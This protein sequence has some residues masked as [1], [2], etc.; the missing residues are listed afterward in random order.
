MSRKNKK[1]V[2]PD[3][4]P[5]DAASFLDSFELKRQEP[6]YDANG[7][8]DYYSEYYG[9]LKND[10]IDQYLDAYRKFKRTG[11]IESIKDPKKTESENADIESFIK[12]EI[13][14]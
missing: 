9:R 13:D 8:R 4:A 11:E 14:A 2:E 12:D 6:V 10:Y 3:T 1:R 7:K 5:S